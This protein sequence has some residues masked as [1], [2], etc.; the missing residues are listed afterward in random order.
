MHGLKGSINNQLTIVFDGKA[1]VFGSFESGPVKVIFSHG[2]SAD[3][4][5]KRIVS[6]AGDKK[7]IVVVTD[8]RDI[9]YAIRALGAK[10]M[11]VK[12][13]LSKAKPSLMASNVKKK[14]LKEN[15]QISNV[16]ESK[17][18]SEFERIW[19]KSKEK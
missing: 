2:E 14:Q 16:L 17:I 5:I 9:Q 19:L 18:T 6:D 13:F 3:E 11:A 1:T 15:K 10:S 7:N 8:D 4:K 12:E